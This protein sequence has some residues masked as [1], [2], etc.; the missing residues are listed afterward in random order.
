MSTLLL[1]IKVIDYENDENARVTQRFLTTQESNK[2]SIMDSFLVYEIINQ[3]PAS[4]RSSL[5]IMMSCDVFL[6]VI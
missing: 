2:S 6:G 3:I 5:S 4:L 1:K